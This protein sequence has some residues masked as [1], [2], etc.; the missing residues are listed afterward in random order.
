MFWLGQARPL[1]LASLDFIIPWLARLNGWNTARVTPAF[2]SGFG[3][4]LARPAGLRYFSPNFLGQ[5]LTP[6]FPNLAGLLMQ[7]L[8]KP[9]LMARVWPGTPRISHQARLLA[10]VLLEF[11]F[12]GHSE[13]GF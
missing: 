6:V 9:D 8:N 3:L 4:V 5:A 2:R 11:L 12:H 13:L 10:P 1:I 7:G